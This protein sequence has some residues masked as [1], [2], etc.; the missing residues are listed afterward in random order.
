MALAVRKGKALILRV[1]NMK[2]AMCALAAA[3]LAAA[4]LAAPEAMPVEWENIDP[5]HHLAG[6]MASAGYLRGKVVCLDYRD[7]GDKSGVD[8][9]RRMEEVWQ[10]FKMKPFVLIGSH[11]GVAGAEKIKR[12]AEGLKL[13]FPIYR[14][15][16]IVRTEE[17]KKT[18]PEHIGFMYIIGGTG[19]ILYC[20]KDDRRA[21]GVIASAIVSMRSPTTVKQWKHYIDYDVNVLPGKALLEIE[22]FRRAFPAEAAAYDEVWEKF[23]ADSGIKRVAKLERLAHMAKDYDL[24][25]PNAKKLS[26]EKIE[27]AIEKA[28]DLKKSENPLV[29]QEAK[30]CI[31]DL[32]WTLAVLKPAGEDSTTKGGKK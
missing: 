13:T 1:G 14:E 23:S 18:D 4:S 24:K 16:D 2:H 12:I 32:T 30:N 10:T 26:A 19:R 6:R 21:A 29:A 3:I 15:A 5:A 8:A 31:A 20:G 11:S 27:Q 9:M 7:Y 22:E 25:D 28:S 17:Q